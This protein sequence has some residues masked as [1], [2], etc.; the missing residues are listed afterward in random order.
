MA[1]KARSNSKGSSDSKGKDP[2]PD[3]LE[4]EDDHKPGF[5]REVTLRLL[6]YLRPYRSEFSVAVLAMLLS[7]IAN[8]AG[9]PLIG[10]AIDEGIRKDDTSDPDRW[11]A[12]LRR[13][14]VGR[15][16]R[17]SHPA[18]QYGH[19]RPDDHQDAARPTL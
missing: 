18:G 8:V 11:C 12:V 3:I 2:L 1:S 7:V 17:L 4:I 13:D 14:T 5:D 10:W 16:H 19:N 9:P 15:F 6:S